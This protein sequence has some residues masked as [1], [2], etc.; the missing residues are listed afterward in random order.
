L[1]GFTL[2]LRNTNLIVRGN[3]NGAGT[4]N[5]CGNPNNPSSSVCVD[6]AIQNNA[7]LSGLTCQTLS[8]E[9]FTFTI[10]NYGLNYIVYDIQGRVVQKGILEE[11]TYE[12]LPIKTLL[13][14]KVDGFANFK[15]YKL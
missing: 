10:N 8:S 12:N 11:S 5:F 6:G 9:T 15:I 14:I 2:T 1:N 3:I 7:N 13:I 4:I